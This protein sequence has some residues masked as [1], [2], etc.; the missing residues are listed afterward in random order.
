MFSALMPSPCVCLSV[1]FCSLLA[2]NW[3]ENRR[4]QKNQHWCER[5]PGQE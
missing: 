3:K 4:L 2:A 5:S 1:H